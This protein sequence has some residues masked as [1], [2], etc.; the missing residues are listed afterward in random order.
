MNT[1]STSSSIFLIYYDFHPI[2][3]FS[4]VIHKDNQDKFMIV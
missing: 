4:V 1:E 3:I 2:R